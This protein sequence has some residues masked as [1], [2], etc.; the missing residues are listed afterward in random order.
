MDRQICLR[1]AV[2]LVAV[3]AGSRAGW[4]ETPAAG[5]VTAAGDNEAPGIVR[6]ALDRPGRASVNLDGEQIAQVPPAPA[7]SLQPAPGVIV[8]AAPAGVVHMPP[9]QAPAYG[10]DPWARLRRAGNPQCVAPWA[11]FTYGPKYCGYYVGGGAALYGCPDHLHGEPRYPHEG[12]WGM[13]YAPWYSRV[14]L[15]W[16]HGTRYQGGEGQYE[17]EEKNNPFEEE[18][19]RPEPRE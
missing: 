3:A 19:Y 11:R 18:L 13:D 7:P 5:V 16:F 6:L 8:E 2:F 15:Q 12:T 17:P 4:A 1:A 10:C 14:R 9:V